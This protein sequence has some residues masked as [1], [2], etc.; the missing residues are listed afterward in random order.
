MIFYDI[1]E[2]IYPDWITVGNSKIVHSSIYYESKCVDIKKSLLPLLLW[3]YRGAWEWSSKT[4]SCWLMSS[5][6]LAPGWWLS[7]SSMRVIDSN[8]GWPDIASSTPHSRQ[9]GVLA[10]PVKCCQSSGLW[11]LW[12]RLTSVLSTFNIS[13][14]LHSSVGR[15]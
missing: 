15:V 12:E 6:R 7:S 10:L 9:V 8:Q 5:W 14:S 3:F 13:A 2:H 1:Q 4:A 11:S